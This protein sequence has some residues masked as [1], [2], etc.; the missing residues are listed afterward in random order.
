[1]CAYTHKAECITPDFS[2]FLVSSQ[3]ELILEHIQKVSEKLTSALY[4]DTHH[5]GLVASNP[6]HDIHDGENSLYLLEMPLP[7]HPARL[8]LPFFMCITQIIILKPANWQCPFFPSLIPSP[9]Q[10]FLLLDSLVPLKLILFVT[11]QNIWVLLV[12]QA[13]EAPRFPAVS[14]I[15]CTPF[16]SSLIKTFQEKPPEWGFLS[17]LTPP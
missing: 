10:N 7:A 6:S 3:H 1:M 17:L 16:L 4:N 14:I 11:Y 12:A 5:D 15:P 13:I 8:F 2:A 9:V